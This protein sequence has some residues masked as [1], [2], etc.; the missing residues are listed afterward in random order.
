MQEKLL[1]SGIN[2][3]Y[4]NDE[5][6]ADKFIESLYLTQYSLAPNTI[7]KNE[8]PDYIIASFNNPKRKAIFIKKNKLCLVKNIDNK[9][10]LYTRKHE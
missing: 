8:I 3:G 2:I 4:K 5:K 6:D 7:L 10:A 1:P 9:M